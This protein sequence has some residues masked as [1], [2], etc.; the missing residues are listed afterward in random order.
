[1]QSVRDHLARHSFRN[2]F[3]EELG[4]DIASGDAV[5]IAGSTS[6]ALRRIAHKRG[7]QAFTCELTPQQLTDRKLLRTI[8]SQLSQQAVEHVA[9]YF[10]EHLRQQCWQWAAVGPSGKRLRH[11]EHPF[12]SRVPSDKVVARIQALAIEFE[13]EDATTLSDVSA[14]L[15]TSFDND[16]EFSSFFRGARWRVLSDALHRRWL[17]TQTDAD[18]NAFLT[19]HLPLLPWA[20][21]KFAPRRMEQEDAAA[22]AFFA[23]RRA[24]QQFD[25][26]HGAQFSTYATKAMMQ[27]IGRLAP[28]YTDLIKCRSHRCRI[29]RQCERQAERLAVTSGEWRGRRLLELLTI[30]RTTQPASVFR[31]VRHIGSF[32]D[33]SAPFRRMLN[34]R[35]DDAPTPLERM[36][37]EE[38]VA[39]I[40]AVL[41]GLPARDAA[42]VQQRFGLGGSGVKATL[43][44]IGTAHR[45][46]KEGVR[47][48]LL[49]V[50]DD[51]RELF[52]EPTESEIT[53]RA[54][55]T[56]MSLAGRDLLAPL[57]AVPGADVTPIPRE[58]AMPIASRPA[59]YTL[60]LQAGPVPKLF[61]GML[62]P[63]LANGTEHPAV[64]GVTDNG[65]SIASADSAANPGDSDIDRVQTALQAAAAVGGM[66][67]TELITTLGINGGRVRAAVHGLAK[68]GEAERGP[69]LR[70]RLVTRKGASMAPPCTPPLTRSNHS[71]TPLPSL[72][73][74]HS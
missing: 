23:L 12:T 27:W 8:E 38:R 62:A 35:P 55:W 2:L 74:A 17:Q 6:F 57:L 3:I 34:E 60:T 65:R 56:P 20:A 15:R 72:F 47:L 16:P 19:I 11:R 26:D 10:C 45:L 36:L 7:V 71:T 48:I 13:A 63:H 46:T 68:S 43:E 70:W 41:A 50:I 44:Q 40:P 64:L 33:R 24:A 1:M 42:I 4:W 54:A 37:H 25:A 29:F 5:A 18:L 59:T 73:D 14:R 32:D 66:L 69:D 58:R 49:R 28:V 39:R 52:D 22:V 31:A 30:R 51:L 53:N 9:I 61:D 67:V 21:K